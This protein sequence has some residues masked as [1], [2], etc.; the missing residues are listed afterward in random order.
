MNETEYDQLYHIFR[1]YDIRGE[2]GKDLTPEVHF[3]IGQAFGTYLIRECKIS[4]KL[5]YVGYD[6][7]KTSPTLVNALMA[8]ILSTGINV[9][10]SGEQVPFGIALYSGMMRKAYATAFV[11]ASHLPPNWNGCK[12]YLGNGVG[13]SEETN[14]KIRDIFFSGDFERADYSQVGQ[15]NIICLKE[16]Y[17]EFFKTRFTLK[18]P[19]KVVLDCGNGAAS[20]I[21]SELF[22][23]L[24]FDVIELYCEPDPMFPNRSSE[25]NEESLKVLVKMVKDEK[26][27]FGVGFDGDGDRAIIVDDQG[28][29]LDADTTGLIIADYYIGNGLVDKKRILANI[30]CTLALEKVLEPKGVIVDRIKVGHT[31]LTLEAT[32]KQDT[33]L[34]IEKSGHMVFPDLFIFDDAIPIPLKV[35][36][37]LVNSKKSLSELVAKL[38]KTFKIRKALKCPDKIKFSVID[39]LAEKFKEEYENINTID[40]VAVR[41]GNEAFV[42]C[43][44][45]NTGPKIR[46]TIESDT[47][48]ELNNLEKKFLPILEEMIKKEIGS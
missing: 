11:T 40:G 44:A 4:N 28:Q 38:P 33:L 16:E 5:V 35:S 30:E 2:F 25:P 12:F 24:N 39:N 8:G 18:D 46:I 17:I 32:K 36:E 1:S 31:Y 47:Q 6:V 29:V 13:F 9:D 48:Q 23:I 34:G 43:R 3:K 14:M 21:A 37:V 26:A 22:K 42:L 19:L 41:I 20:L 10:F 15:S 27:D 45:S 7:R